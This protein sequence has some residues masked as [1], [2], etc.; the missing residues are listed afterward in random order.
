MVDEDAGISSTE[1]G[2]EVEGLGADSGKF[3]LDLE[4]P[5]DQPRSVRT[6][7]RAADQ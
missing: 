1:R 4:A 6:S 3:G 5:S 7:T 2:K